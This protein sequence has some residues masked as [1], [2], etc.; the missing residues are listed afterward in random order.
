[1]IPSAYRS[2]A[3]VA[4]LPMA[5][6]GARYWAVPMTMPVAV[7][8]RWLTPVEMPKSVSLARPSRL[9]RMLEGLTSRWMTPESCTTWSARATWAR[10]GRIS[11]GAMVPLSVMM[12]DSARPWTSSMMIQPEPSRSPASRTMARLG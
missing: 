7:I 4:M 8:G 12:S 6:S 3:A 11:A 1:M 5:C 10:I 2:P 9:I